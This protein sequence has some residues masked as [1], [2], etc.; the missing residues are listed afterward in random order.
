MAIDTL[1][2]QGADALENHFAI[3]IAPI[4]NLPFAPLSFR[5]LTLSIPERSFE[6][7]EKHWGTQ[8]YTTPAGKITTPNE[9]SMSFRLDRNYALYTL[10]TTWMNSIADEVTGIMTPDG[11]D[12]GW[13]TDISVATIDSNGLPT[14]TGWTFIGCFP[15]TVPGVEFNMES[16]QPLSIDVTLQFIRMISGLPEQF[17]NAAGNFNG[18]AT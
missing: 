18:F 15:S 12:S 8:V 9:F 2:N 13:R 3:S 11:P 4:I 6:T 7:Y 1:F 10:F 16:G 17:E 14:S 5:V